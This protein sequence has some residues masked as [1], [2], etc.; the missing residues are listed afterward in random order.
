MAKEKM[1]FWSV[2]AVGIGGMVG[3]GI[4]AVLGLSVELAQGGAPIAFVVAGLI[5]LVTTYAYVQLSLAFPSR[6]GTVTFLNKAFGTGFFTG[7]INLLLW[8]SYIVMLSLYASAFG[9]YGAAFFPESVQSLMRHILISGS[10]IGI[11]GLNLL[12]ADVIGK[13]ESWIVAFKLLI[14]LVFI[15]IGVQGVDVTR[16]EPQ[17]WADPLAIV[18]GGMIIFLAFEGFELMANTAEEV[19]HPEHVLPRAYYSAVGFVLVLYLLIAGITVGSL[20]TDKIIEA[21]EYAL[22]VAAKPF[23][24]SVG[25]TM[26]AIAALLSTASALNAT[27]YGTSRLSYIIAKSGELPAALEKKIWNQPIEGLLITS[28][29]TLVIANSFNLSEISTM[30]SSGFLLIFAVVNFAN[31]RLHRQTKSHQWISLIG[32]VA[33]LGAVIVLLSETA[34]TQPQHLW[35]VVAMVGLAFAIE[36]IY[37]GLS[38]RQ[39]HLFPS[40]TRTDDPS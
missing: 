31:V 6:G 28:G 13:A 22:A 37:R 23:M 17:N 4:F 27:L 39:I 11:T 18:S 32:T 30:G 2:T 33:C 36:G 5:A 25:F 21:K 14:L 1:G 9:S 16:L 10:I 3:G 8:L 29:L 24:G 19:H 7:S 26:I 40:D 12:S 20:S 15:G 38:Q 35:V 34:R